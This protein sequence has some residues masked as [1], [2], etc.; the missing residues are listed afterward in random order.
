MPKMSSEFLLFEKGL[1][2]R[3]KSPHVDIYS[4]L[5]VLNG[6]KIA[7]NQ[8]GKTLKINSCS[9]KRNAKKGIREADLWCGKIGGLLV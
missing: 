1:R 9:K 8:R 5:I 6:D 4:R 7:V 3:K 2:E